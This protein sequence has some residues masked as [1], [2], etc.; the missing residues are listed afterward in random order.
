[1]GKKKRDEGAKKKE[2]LGLPENGIL[3]SMET[4]GV[5]IFG[6]QDYWAQDFLYYGSI[7]FIHYKWLN[8]LRIHY[9]ERER[10]SVCVCVCVM[11]RRH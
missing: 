5:Q 10:E 2:R 3:C 11:D 8:T 6:W 9:G 1:M 7:A 4:V